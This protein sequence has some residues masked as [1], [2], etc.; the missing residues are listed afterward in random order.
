M[1][2]QTPWEE[3]YQKLLNLYFTKWQKF[4]FTLYEFHGRVGQAVLC[5]H[6]YWLYFSDVKAKRPKKGQFF[7]LY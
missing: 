3:I 4:V 2:F 5:P 7:G 1:H 6:K